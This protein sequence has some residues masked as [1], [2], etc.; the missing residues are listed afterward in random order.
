[1]FKKW[2]GGIYTNII[3]GLS[4]KILCFSSIKESSS[5]FKDQ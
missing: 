1:M 5:W 2:Q 4:I 3:W